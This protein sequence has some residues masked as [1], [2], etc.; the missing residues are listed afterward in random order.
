[1]IKILFILFSFNIFAINSIE[2]SA[3]NALVDKKSGITR[4]I[5]DVVFVQKHIELKADEVKIVKTS[6]DN[7]Q[8]LAKSEGKKSSHFIKHDTK[9]VSSAREIIY[10][11]DQKV[12]NLNGNAKL[13]QNGNNF[14]G[15]VI[16][17][18][19][20]NDKVIISGSEGKRVN[21]KIKL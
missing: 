14:N 6:T 15:E 18:D 8:I 13:S 2:I 7:Y 5:G 11:T 20:K 1:M 10:L 19:I 16:D 4:Y 3:N 17:Y 21:I 9:I 12:V